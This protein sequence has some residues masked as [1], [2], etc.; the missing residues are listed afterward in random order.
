MRFWRYHRLCYTEPSPIEVA[1]G[2]K[3]RLILQLY[4]SGKTTLRVFLRD[5]RNSRFSPRSV[6]FC[7]AA[8]MLGSNSCLAAWSCEFP[9]TFDGSLP[10]ELFYSDLP[11]R[12]LNFVFHLIIQNIT[13]LL[14]ISDSGCLLNPVGDGSPELTEIFVVAKIAAVSS[15]AVF[16]DHLALFSD[17][18]ILSNRC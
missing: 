15:G 7:S 16:E 1:P 9:L 8:W 10:I 13:T 14:F 18:T 12:S 4:N 6:T 3:V 5:R 2:N 11:Y 17:T